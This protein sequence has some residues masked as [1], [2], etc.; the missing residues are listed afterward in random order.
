[1]EPAH[2]ARGTSFNRALFFCAAAALASDEAERE[3]LITNLCEALQQHELGLR[4]KE[5]DSPALLDD[6]GHS[7]GFQLAAEGDGSTHESLTITCPEGVGPGDV[8]SIEH[9]GQ[10]FEIE[11]PEGVEPGDDFEINLEVEQSKE[12][13]GEPEADPLNV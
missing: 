7:A 12:E 4:I 1:M 10:E 2:G 11:V 3:R 6:P 8:L 9:N 13:V 5:R